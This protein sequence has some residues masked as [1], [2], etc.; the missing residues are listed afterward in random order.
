MRIIPRYVMQGFLLTFAVTLLVFTFI[1]CTLVLFKAVDYIAA[2]GDFVTILKIFLTGLP[3]A[4]AIS[5]PISVLT[6]ALLTFGRLSA[7]GEIT[8]MK[9]S[10]ISM[11]MIILY[12]LLFSALMTA[13]CFYLNAELAPIS[14]HIRRQALWNLG[15]NTPLTLIEEGRFITDFPGIAFYVGD[16]KG[17]RIFNVII[18]RQSGNF[19]RNIR[20]KSGTVRLSSDRNSL[21]VDLVDVRVDPFTDDRPGPGYSDFFPVQIDLPS[22]AQALN[23]PKKRSDLTMRE[24]L[25]QIDA[26]LQPSAP[27][28]DQTDPAQHRMSLVVEYHKRIVLALSC[29]AFM[30]LGAPLATRTHRTESSIG[31][32]ISLFLVF[33]FYLFIVIADSLTKR[34][35]LMPYLITWIPIAI[36][37]GL[38]AYLVRRCE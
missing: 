27:K 9:A 20:A 22:K 21:I 19:L 38:G 1:M 12:P 4:M 2:G 24:L 5:I 16:K 33:N 28:A 25:E 31:V 15:M 6:A 35:D 29:I 3:S 32:A 8:A 17:N 26:P 37:F 30:V 14:Y 13:L 23:P 11:K 36:S 34:P 18:Y 7:Q 10:G